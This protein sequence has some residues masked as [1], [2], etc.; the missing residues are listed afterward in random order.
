MAMT[1]SPNRESPMR[2]EPTTDGDRVD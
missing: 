2:E 1:V